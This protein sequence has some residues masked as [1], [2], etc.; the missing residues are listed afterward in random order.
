MAK[1]TINNLNSKTREEREDKINLTLIL[2]I[3]VLISILVLFFFK[4]III[5][6]GFV[7]LLALGLIFFEKP[8]IGIYIII[9]SILGG[10][11]LKI[12]FGDGENGLLLSDMIIPFFLFCW[13][14]RL[15]IKRDKI[16][17]TLVGPFLLVFLSMAVISLVYGLRVLESQE[18]L[19]SSFYLFRLISYSLLFFAAATIFNRSQKRIYNFNK[20]FL[21]T[22][23]L[24]ALLGI[25]QVIIFPDLTAWAIKYGWDPHIGR[26][27]STF[28]DPNFAGVFLTIGFIFSLAIFLNAKTIEAKIITASVALLTLVGV[29]L[30]YSRSSY[31]F[32]AIAFF[33]FAL[34]RQ[35]RL[36]LI[37]LAAIIIL[38]LIFPRSL[39]RIE[40]GFDID[41]SAKFRL[42]SWDN[43][44]TII[45]DNFWLGVGYNAFRHA[46]IKYGFVKANEE[47]RGATGSDSSILF[48][49]VTTG[50]SGLIS[51]L[52]FYFA[53]LIK[54][55]KILTY[56]LSPPKRALAL[57]LLATLVGL[58]F[59]SFFVN[60]LFYPPI[61]IIIFLLLGIISTEPV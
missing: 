37:G 3:L 14:L 5:F 35:K 11:L 45:K 44:T 8:Q 25:F 56:S 40:S 33:V 7:F 43:S 9:I 52:T 54:A 30:T 55:K 59:E 2:A 20:I 51:Y 19:I 58:I 42:E 31:L 4:S 21:L 12:N 22:F 38:L 39:E 57:V 46:Q 29:I 36:L 49:F 24:F 18:I 23:A 34:I 61:M 32:L 28:L 1:N 16:P 41:K 10:Q 50:I 13:F 27:F 48:V 17:S 15:I 53:S 47:N 60:S 26:L 6:F